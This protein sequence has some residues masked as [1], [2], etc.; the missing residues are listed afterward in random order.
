MWV[1]MKEKTVLSLEIRRATVLIAA[2]ILFLAGIIPTQAEDTTGQSAA[3]TVYHAD[4]FGRMNTNVIM[5]TQGAFRRWSGPLD[6]EYEMPSSYQQLG[7][8]SGVNPAYAQASI[9][10]E[11]KPAKFIQIRLQ[12]DLQG[13]FG[14][15]GALLSFPSDDAKFGKKEV[16][17]L[18]GQ[19]D[20]GWGHRLLLQPVI[21][22]KVGPVIIRNNTDLAYYRI[23][24]RG[25]YF[26]EW[27]YDTLLKDGDF[28]INNMT[29]FLVEA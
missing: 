29:A 16:D 9:Y 7:I 6:P 4:I 19:E 20:T 3:E 5:L 21:T 8:A 27:E 13:Y 11:W 23:G 25:P 24:G 1:I 26:Y 28:L 18:S 15:N 17:E 2:G 10:G 12:Y 22:G 14:E